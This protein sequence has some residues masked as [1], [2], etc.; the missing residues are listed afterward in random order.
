[1]KC[2]QKTEII[3]IQ[4]MFLVKQTTKDNVTT[5]ELEEVSE[6]KASTLS[7][8]QPKQWEQKQISEHDDVGWFCF[9]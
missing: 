1:M 7:N 8:F 6:L 4:K 3:Q 2:F 5:I 9:G